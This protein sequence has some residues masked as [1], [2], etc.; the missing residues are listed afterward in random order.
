MSSESHLF[1]LNV[2]H[3]RRILIVD[4]RE[5]ERM[6]LATY[7]QQQGCRVYLANDGQDGLRK[8]QL[9]QPDMVLMDITMPVCDGLTACRLMKSD[10]LLRNIPIIFL[11][12]AALPEERVKG[13]LAGAVDYVT[14]PFDFEEVRL[15]LA[16]HLKEH[17]KADELD[18][19]EAPVQTTLAS[20]SSL[21]N[22]L[23]QS[24]RVHLLKQATDVPD[25]QAL[26]AKVGTN[27]RRLNEAFKN[28]VGV[29]VFEY[30]RELRMKEACE[31][32]ADTH[33]EVQAIAIE[34]GFTSGA[35]FATAFKLRYGVS[36][37]QFRQ[38]RQ[39]PHQGTAGVSA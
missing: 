3:A 26:A 32:L 12:G 11:T 14:K 36:P 17:G 24:A 18:R 27:A 7:L 6:L 19:D 38:T 13:L 31:L 25:L 9:V 15:R 1:K 35:N 10:A 2:L 8:A 21:D 28:C 4:D 39:S 30:L 20:T 5:A 37:T 34:L 23:F 33:I 16:V 29:T 22:M